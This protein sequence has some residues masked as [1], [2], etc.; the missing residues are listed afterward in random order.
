MNYRR[1]GQT[2]L[3]LSEISLGSWM[4]AGNAVEEKTAIACIRRA[5]E[6]GVNYFDSADVYAQRRAEQV[7]A[8]AL[9][10]IRREDYVLASK[11]FFPASNSVLDRGLSRQH[12][13]TSVHKTL[14]SF[15]SDYVDLFYSHRFDP[16]TPLEE[17]IRAFEDL[18]RAGN[19]LYWG[20][21]DWTAEQIDNAVALAGRLGAYAP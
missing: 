2:G 1:M 21:S 18:I 17:T 5:Y 12:I 6:L 9:E 13:H 3:K 10:S 4:T 16:E 14:K 15:R 20:T 11:C 8:K 19:V 7:T